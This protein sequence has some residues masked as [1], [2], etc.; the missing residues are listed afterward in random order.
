ML[1]PDHKIYV[2]GHRG[3]VGS[4]F[5]RALK[6]KGYRSILT[7]TREELDLLDQQAVRKFLKSEKPDFIILAAARVG[8]I[9]ANMRY[10]ADFIYENLMVEC[11]AIHGAHEAGIENL[12]FL[13][14]SCIY[15]KEAPQ[16]IHEDALLTGPLEPTNAPYAL[17]KIAGLSLCESFNRQYGRKYRSVM[18]TNLYGIGDNFDTE[19]AHVIPAL[20]SR[21]HTAKEKNLPEVL[22]WGTGTPRR[23][24]LYSDDMADACLFLLENVESLDL[25]NI[26]SG[27]DIAISDLATMI[28]EAVGYRGTIV[29]DSGKPDGMMRKLLN[30]D[31]LKNLGWHQRTPLR[32]GIIRTY[33]WF[34][35]H[36]AGRP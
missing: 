20:M 23:E 3:L 7:V 29:F 5:V 11:N 15:P 36:Q 31:R 9:G 6:A 4:A 27:E 16:P 33:D 18:P 26:G 28:A 22:L 10:P 14:S 21:I 17:S 25:I 35:T 2:A 19:N 32:D 13:G 12:L 8:G 34:R 1:T 24:F 30:V